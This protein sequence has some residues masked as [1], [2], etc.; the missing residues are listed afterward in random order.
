MRWKVNSF[1]NK[2]FKTPA[3]LEL[4]GILKVALVQIIIAVVGIAEIEICR[5]LLETLFTRKIDKLLIC[6]CFFICIHIFLNFICRTLEH[7]TMT[8]RGEITMSLRMHILKKNESLQFLNSEDMNENDKL[9]IADGDCER[10]TDSLLGM[11]SLFSSIIVTPCYI[12][13]GFTIN[14]WITV[15][16]IVVSFCLSLLNKKNKLKL[17]KCNEELNDSYGY[18]ANYLWKALDNLEV[19]KVFLSKDKIVKEQRIRNNNLCEVEQKTLKTYL[20]VCLIEESSDMVFTMIIL[21][22]SFFAILNHKMS[23]A[24]ILAI[25]EALT[26]V[27][28]NIFQLPEQMIRLNELESIASRIYKLENM[29]E[30]KATEELNEDFFNLTVNDIFFNYQEDRILNGINY[31]FQKGKFYVIVGASGCGKTTLLKVIARLIPASEGTVYWNEKDLSKI[32][33][34]SIYK[35]MSYISQNKVFLENTIRDNICLDEPDNE[36]Y[37][38]VLEETFL[39]SVFEKNHSDDDL[40]ITLSG[41]PLSSG[42][43][44][45]VSFANILYAKKQLILLD[46]AFSAIDP[47]KEKHFYKCIKEL[48]KKGATVILVSHRLTNINMSD[49]IL[50]MEKGY[51]KESGSFDELCEKGNEFYVWYS[52]NKEANAE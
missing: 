51:I 48:T 32:T 28:K 17:C 27:Q 47:A 30:D 11:T 13:Y 9:S 40:V 35:K 43:C 22:L 46:E 7:Y 31:K 1:L 14:V 20:D 52:M 41:F 2:K 37:Q 23:A 12:I 8:V 18:W 25:V 5:Q 39:Q 15:L 34:D 33:R 10:Y 38:K 24:S 42:E 50:F 21:C 16:I 36:I 26:S 19:I 3:E 44:Q 4:I 6:C 49:C 45:M 29:E